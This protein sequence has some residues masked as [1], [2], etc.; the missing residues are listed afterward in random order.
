MIVLGAFT[1]CGTGDD[2]SGPPTRTTAFERS[3]LTRPA[4][5]GTFEAHSCDVLSRRFIA[6]SLGTT[7]PRLKA[8]PND[9]LDLSIC[10][11][12]GGPVVGVKL[13]VDSAPRAQL[14]YYNLLSEQH[15]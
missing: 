8:D 10:D 9:S 15:E 7:A 3:E 4:D 6:R 2:D 1:G 5:S 12:H 11:W 13:M 14:R